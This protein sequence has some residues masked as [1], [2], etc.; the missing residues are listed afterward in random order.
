VSESTKAPILI[1]AAHHRRFGGGAGGFSLMDKHLLVETEMGL[2]WN[3]IWTRR[4]P[5]TRRCALGNSI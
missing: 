1:R 2:I 5:G 3:F 4:A